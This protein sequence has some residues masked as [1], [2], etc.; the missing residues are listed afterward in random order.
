M[1]NIY[2]DYAKIN[3][4]NLAAMRMLVRVADSGS[5]SAAARQLDIAPS[6]VSRLISELEDD[7]GAPLFQRTTRKLNL[8]EAGHIYYEHA[9]KIIMEL[10][11]ARLAV[12]QSG[13]PSGILRMTS[14]TAIGREFLISIIPAFLKEYPG[15]RVVMTL[16]DSVLDLVESGIDLAIRVGP[17]GDSTLKARK[18]GNSRRVIC[19]SPDYLKRMGTP[20]HPKELEEHNCVTFR[21]HPGYNLWNFRGPEGL[22]KV[23]ATGNFFARSSDGVLAAALAGM[24]FI[25]MPDWNMGIELKKKQLRVVLQDYPLSPVDTPVWALHAHQRHVPPKVRAFIDFL[26]EHLAGA[27]F[28]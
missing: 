25:L 7:L 6:S 27:E 9:N 16:S 14:P 10:D 13:A 21:N 28:S 3:M 15:V 11:E 23:K 12:S 2:A 20:K 26:V 4:D 8:T 17:L 19:A 24:G 1:K 5:F 22:I 18:L